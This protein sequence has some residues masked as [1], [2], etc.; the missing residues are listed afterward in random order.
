MNKKDSTKLNVLSEIDDDI[1]EKQSIRRYELLA[2]ARAK[3]SNKKAIIPKRYGQYT[4]FYSTIS[5]LSQSYS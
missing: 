5:P 1:I 4:L 2:K 3:R